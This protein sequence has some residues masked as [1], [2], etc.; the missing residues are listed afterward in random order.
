M[1]ISLT[2]SMLFGSFNFPT[3]PQVAI[4]VVKWQKLEAARLI[5]SIHKLSE[6]PDGQ[7]EAWTW[8]KSLFNTQ[9]HT[10][11]DELF[12]WSLWK[13]FYWIVL[14]MNRNAIQDCRNSLLCQDLPR[15]STA[16]DSEIRDSYLSVCHA[17]GGMESRSWVSGFLS[18]AGVSESLL[19]FCAKMI[20]MLQ[21]STNLRCMFP[22][23][24]S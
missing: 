19:Y 17:T 21:N 7:K 22:D 18:L 20:F 24:N 3:I 13:L 8:Q 15:K 16:R 2:F 4:Q 6:P 10:Q 5:S 12:G 11:R 9:Y 23:F 1:E 14:P